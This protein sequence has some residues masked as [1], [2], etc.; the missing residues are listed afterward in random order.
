MKILYLSGHSVLE[1]DEI[2]MFHDL[3]HEVLSLGSYLRPGSPI[4]PKRP[5]LQQI[6]EIPELV[7]IVSQCPNIGRDNLPKEV[8]GWADCVI[9]AALPDKWLIP[10]WK[11]IERKR[12]VWRTIGQSN[13]LLELKMREY[14][15]KGVQI[16]RYSPAEERFFRQVPQQDGTTIDY[17]A[18]Q[19]ALIRFGKYPEDWGGWTGERAVVGN[20]AQHNPTP[21]ERDLFINWKWLQSAVDGLPFEFAGSHSE[22]IGGLGELSYDAMRQKLREWRAYIYTCTIPASYSL[23]MIEALFTGVPIVG[24]T[25]DYMW[26]GPGLYEADEIVPSFVNPSDANDA[27]RAILNDWN[28]A[29]WK[30]YGSRQT[31]LRLF[32]ANVIKEQWR[33][34]LGERYD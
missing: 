2:R 20:I 13:Y 25:R 16:V 29:K 17:F 18:G 7:D 9:V 31:A 19:D 28:T 4:D 22:K 14:H 3:G 33:R 8:V 32:D 10:N 27:L 11:L 30:S 26:S 1:Y 15:D 34:F 21:H 24:I 12:P 23:T 6:P 5:S